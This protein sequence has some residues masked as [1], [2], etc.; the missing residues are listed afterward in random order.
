MIS[1]RHRVNGDKAF[2]LDLCLPCPLPS[3]APALPSDDDNTNIIIICPPSLVK[4]FVDPGKLTLL[5]IFNGLG[6]FVFIWVGLLRGSYRDYMGTFSFFNNV[7][8]CP[9]LVGNCYFT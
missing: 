5:K 8:R 1:S 9:Y 7:D 6:S 4:T 2:M 3:Y